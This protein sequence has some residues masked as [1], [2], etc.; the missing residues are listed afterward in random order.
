MTGD[1]SLLERSLKKLDARGTSPQTA[2]EV[3]DLLLSGQQLKRLLELG[4]AHLP[5]SSGL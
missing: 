2:D 5:G 3:S 4:D 1:I